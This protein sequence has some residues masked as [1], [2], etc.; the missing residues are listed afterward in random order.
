MPDLKSLRQELERT[1]DYEFATEN[2]VLT[3]RQRAKELDSADAEARSEQ[4][5]RLRL[6]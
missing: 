2:A 5:A 6:S 1:R 3:Q 4:T